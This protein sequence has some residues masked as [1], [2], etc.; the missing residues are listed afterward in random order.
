[1]GDKKAKAPANVSADLL[2]RY[3]RAAH[4]NLLNLL[5]ETPAASF[6]AFRFQI[7]PTLDPDLSFPP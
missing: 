6:V 1:V 5:Q 3:L 7:G 4:A 2:T